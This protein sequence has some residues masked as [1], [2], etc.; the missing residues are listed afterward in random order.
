MLNMPSGFPT[1]GSSAQIPAHPK[2]MP[3]RKAWQGVDF[4]VGPVGFEP[5]AMSYHFSIDLFQY[6]RLKP[7]PLGRFHL[8]P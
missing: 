8:Q 5:T 4:V 7:P 3:Y 2:K 1:Q 6:V